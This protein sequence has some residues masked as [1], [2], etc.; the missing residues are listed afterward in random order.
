MAN[1]DVYD[2]LQL[3][4]AIQLA[5]GGDTI[6][7]AAT[8][9]TTYSSIT[10]LA[11]LFCTPLPTNAGS[12][13][14][15][16]NGNK[17]L[18][19]RLYQQNVDGPNG[20]SAVSN[21]TLDYTSG[22]AADGGALF[23]ATSGT[24]AFSNLTF[25]GT[26]GGWAG[27]G[28]TYFSLTVATA[29]T[30]INT[31]LTLSGSTV[32]LKGQA[33]FNETTGVGGSAFV[34]SWNNAGTVK[35]QNNTF[36]DTGYQAAFH[37][38]TMQ[39]PSNPTPQLGTYEISGNTFT[40]DTPQVRARG[41]RLD[42]VSATVSGNTFNNGT[43][44]DLYGDVSNITIT[45][46]TFNLIPGGVG[47]R[48]N[49]TSS[50]GNL[51]VGMPIMPA[52]I[53][54]ATPN[55]FNGDGIPLKYV[56]TS[57]GGMTMN[58]TVVINGSTFQSMTAGTQGPDNLTLNGLANW[59]NGDD[60]NDTING[61]AGNDYLLGGAGNDSILGGNNDDTLNGGS[62]ADT[63]NGEAGIDILSYVGSPAGVTVNLQNNTANGGD[64]TGDVI[65]NF[66]GVT[67]SSFNDT[68]T[69]SAANNDLLSGGDGNDSL[70]GG[71][72]SGNDTL[73]GGNGTDTLDGGNGNDLLIGG[74]G[75]DNIIGGGGIDTASYVGSPA[76]V[77]V[78]LL[79]GTGSGGD[80]QGD[81]LSSVENL[82]GS[83][84]G[85]TLT[86]DG[87]T[88]LLDGADGADTLNG[89]AGAD[90]LLGGLG[91]DSMD[92][93]AGNDSLTGGMGAD[94]LTGGSQN[95]QFIYNATDEGIDII[96]DF[97]NPGNDKLA[98]RST[99]FGNL[100]SLN[101][102]NLFVNATGTGGAGT[103]PQFIFNTTTKALVYD[104][105]GSAAGNSFGIATLNG[106]ATLSASDFVFF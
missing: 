96:T 48:L 62:G 82:T 57:P 61:L 92:G 30:P 45:G 6:T 84:F 20:P 12:Y 74:A 97:N 91:T 94:T 87:G 68:L 41:N 28:N 29:A 102:T 79:A 46:N 56:G 36:N 49:A 35:L 26:H 89:G 10:T 16:G 77:T 37:F 53:P 85:D 70:N 64:A 75:P 14:I 80:A 105:N 50:S 7:L 90:T 54:L 69:G 42:N 86:G 104:S 31:N 34:Q 66:E 100:T 73:Q 22:G 95:D 4:N 51:L 106:V 44:L 5:T 93:A 25:T 47:I 9:V 59:V 63:L 11:K 78:S 67:G 101:A 60:G 81:T 27:N 23:R 99:A 65:S 40:R 18:N 98:F 32:S 24:Y 15:L 13:S 103:N 88:N 8:P 58:A 19:T 2:S 52:A 38:V 43:Y 39:P 3:R 55:I 71:T 21:L 83:S 1:F 72:G 76:A 17:L 33:N